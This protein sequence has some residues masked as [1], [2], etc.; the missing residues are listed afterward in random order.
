M[1][2][3][4]NFEKFTLN[5]GIRVLT[6]PNPNSPTVTFSIS[7][8]A[9]GR[10]EKPSQLGLAHFI[11]HNFFK[12]SKKYPSFREV[13][14]A[15]EGVGG[16]TN[17][18]TSNEMTSYFAK[19]P[20][21]KLP[22]ILDVVSDAFLNPLFPEDAI[23][24]EKQIIFEEIN[25]YENLP[26][27]KVIEEL[28]KLA[29]K[30]SPLGNPVIGNKMTVSKFKKPDLIDFIN[31]GYGGKEV[32]ICIS[33]G[34]DENE[35]FKLVKKYFTNYPRQSTI[36]RNKVKIEQSRP[37]VVL[38]EKPLDQGHFALSFFGLPSD[39]PDH[40]VL[41]V[42]NAVLGVGASS[43]VL[44]KIREE[45]GL[46][47]YINSFSW[48]L[49]DAGLWAVTGGVTIE[50]IEEAITQ[51]LKEFKKLASEKVSSKEI[52]R[53]KEY[54]KGGMYMGI[55]SSDGLGGFYAYQELLE[56]KVLSPEEKAKKVDGV[57][58]AD[59]KRIV[60]GLVKES[61]LNLSVVGPYKDPTKFQKILKL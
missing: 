48:D 16:E 52:T 23:D 61:H 39:H 55:E 53:A 60:S 9:G 41:E 19:A 25:M 27:K 5:N 44:T 13:F 28:Q 22:K 40:Y 54:L 43:R 15:I 51:T 32:V 34:I 14:S 17:A 11:E 30:G 56:K 38:T 21:S 2:K 4:I 50:K 12:G 1:T 42:A 26:S 35:A 47:Y 18:F 59:V 10:D 31:K 6:V 29:F 57:S 3:K 49:T 33:G 7:V 58:S 36:S 46:A 45:M 8:R 24:K 37:Q 20:K